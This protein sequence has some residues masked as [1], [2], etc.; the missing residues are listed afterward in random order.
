M[1]LL[2]RLERLL[3]R[4]AIPRITIYIIFLQ[5]LAYVL[6]MASQARQGE[7]AED[8]LSRLVLVGSLVRHGEVWRLF[9]FVVIPPTTNPIF[10]FFSMY[11]LYLM[12]MALENHWGTVRFNLFLLVGWVAS[13]AVSLALPMLPATNAYLMESIFLAFAFLFPEFVIYLFFVL[14]IKVKWLALL[15]WILYILQFCVGTWLDKALIVAAIANFLLFFHRELLQRVRGGHRR[16]LVR[17]QST[18][19][20]IEPFH[21]CTACGVTERS[22]RKMEFRYCPQCAGTPCYCINH[23]N[24]HA[25]IPATHSSA[26]APEGSRT[27][28]LVNFEASNDAV[29]WRGRLGCG[30]K[31]QPRRPCYGNRT[32]P[33]ISRSLH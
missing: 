17:A 13:V 22:D 19:L 8:F 5:S 14:P 23:I 29:T 33:L 6:W 27:N 31:S 24:A 11:F 16:M 25:H 9:T 2:A 32:S 18:A 10:F 20:A 1:K 21:R 3:G 30:P 7:G 28:S 26:L 12:G 15:T 4:Y